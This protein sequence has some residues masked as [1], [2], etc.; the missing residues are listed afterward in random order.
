MEGLVDMDETRLLKLCNS[1]AEEVSNTFKY[2]SYS[3]YTAPHSF[4][5]PIL[6]LGSQKLFE[7]STVRVRLVRVTITFIEW[8]V[9][10]MT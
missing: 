10:I 9:D 3:T 4:R 2:R 7:L 6:L 5:R 8:L 1:H